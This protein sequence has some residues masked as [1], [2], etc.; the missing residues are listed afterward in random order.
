MSIDALR[1]KC[2]ELLLAVLV[3][4]VEVPDGKHHVSSL[5]PLALDEGCALWPLDF[6]FFSLRYFH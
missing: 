5:G 1:C 3:H 2:H 4:L 6:M